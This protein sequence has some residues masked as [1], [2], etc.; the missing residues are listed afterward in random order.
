SRRLIHSLRHETPSSP[1]P[2]T[3]P[4]DVFASLPH[5]GKPK[6]LQEMETGIAAK[7]GD[8]QIVSHTGFRHRGERPSLLRESHNREPIDSASASSQT[9]RMVPSVARPLMVQPAA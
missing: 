1:F 4:P 5:R 3:R 7:T 9:A 2:T 6:T 8:A